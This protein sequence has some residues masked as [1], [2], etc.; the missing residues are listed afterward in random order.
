MTDVE[1]RVFV[2]TCK[3]KGMKCKK[4]RDNF[5]RKFHKKGPIINEISENRICA[6][7]Q[8]K[9]APKKIW[10]KNGIGIRIG[11]L[12]ECRN[13]IIDAIQKITPQMLGSVFWE[14]IYRFE[15][16]G[17]NDGHHVETNK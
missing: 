16:C 7:W 5:E 9:W 14:T 3:I 10:G 6:W 11:D 12:A 4:I 13:R 15:L 1:E 2:V 8:Q 17:D